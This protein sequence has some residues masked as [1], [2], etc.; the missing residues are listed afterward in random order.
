MVSTGGPEAN[1]M[2]DDISAGP[3][4][5]HP[6]ILKELGYEIAC[7][8][9]VECNLL[10]TSDWYQR[11]ERWQMKYQFL[12]GCRGHLGSYRPG[13]SISIFKIKA[14]P[15]KTRQNSKAHNCLGL[16]SIG[17]GCRGKWWNQHLWRCLKDV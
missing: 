2:N 10:L 11:N 3:Y 15:Q 16:S 1:S 13:S 5:V 8:V 9:T 14:K 17:R 6:V 7:Q 12:R 4:D